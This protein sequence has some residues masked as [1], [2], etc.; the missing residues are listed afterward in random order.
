MR[1][2]IERAVVVYDQESILTGFLPE[3]G[4]QNFYDEGGLEDLL[5]SL[6][7]HRRNPVL[8]HAASGHIRWRTIE[9]FD[10][11]HFQETEPKFFQ[12]GRMPHTTERKPIINLIQFGRALTDCQKQ[13][14]GIIWDGDDRTALL[15]LLIKIVAPI[16]DCLD[17]FVWLFIHGTPPFRMLKTSSGV[18][19]VSFKPSTYRTAYASGF[20]SLR[21]RQRPF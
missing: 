2:L 21:P 18:V 20:Y 8:H 6:F 15:E 10:V 11:C 17:P 13:N 19:L 7:D 16:A 14:T 12:I 4:K 9:A 1:A 5:K 3:L